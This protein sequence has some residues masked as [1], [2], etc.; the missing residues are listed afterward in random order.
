MLDDKIV[1]LETACAESN[2]CVCVC[3]LDAT[4]LVCVCVCVLDDKIVPLEAA[5]GDPNVCVGV[6]VHML[7]HVYIC[8]D[9]CI[10]TCI[11][12]V[13]VHTRAL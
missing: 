5:C 12:C 4:L 1:T 11:V 8:T 2:V 9:A 13:Y 7:R 10:Y 6:C 3:V